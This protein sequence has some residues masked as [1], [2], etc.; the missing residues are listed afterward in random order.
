MYYFMMDDLERNLVL[1]GS[2]EDISTPLHYYIVVP[3]PRKRKY[4]ITF[5]TAF[6]CNNRNTRWRCRV[7]F[8]L[9]CLHI[10]HTTDLYNP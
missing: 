10:C 9:N 2:G 7:I 5:L 6:Q 3:T 8:T 4:L 1:L